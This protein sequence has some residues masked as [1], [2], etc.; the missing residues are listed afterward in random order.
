MNNYSLDVKL[1]TQIFQT[2]TQ[3]STL[4]V[5]IR[6]SNHDDS[7][8]QMMRKIDTFGDF[9]TSHTK[10]NCASA[11]LTCFDVVLERNGR[12]NGVSSLNEQ[13]LLLENNVNKALNT[14][15]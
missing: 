4:C 9:S 13:K 2:S 7:S 3:H 14:R 12:L 10:Q 1:I 5:L 15:M 8:S 11:T 6:N